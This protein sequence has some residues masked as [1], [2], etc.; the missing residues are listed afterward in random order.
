[1]GFF[2][3]VR[4]TNP[5]PATR[6]LQVKSSAGFTRELENL[7][8]F[9]GQLPNLRYATREQ[10]MTVPAIARS[11]NILA[12]SIGTIPLESYNKMTGAH[13]NNRTLIVQPDPALPRVN[14]ITWLVDDLIFYGV[15]YLQVLELIHFCK[16]KL[17]LFVFLPNS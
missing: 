17:L 6:E 13:I 9:P 14:T 8:S 10:A 4:L 7:Y 12:G 1:M 3:A 16:Y 2:N 15:G 11:R 5:E